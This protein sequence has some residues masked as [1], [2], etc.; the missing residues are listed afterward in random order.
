[1]AKSSMSSKPKTPKILKLVA[2]I[3][4]IAIATVAIYGALTY[5][6]TVLSLSVSFTVGADVERK[7]FD[8]PF[9][10]SW[11]QV[12]VAV[13]SGSALW[14]AR[15][16]NQNETLWSHTSAQGEQTAYKSAWMQLSSGTYNFTFAT[17]GV[18]SL[19]AEITLTSKGGFW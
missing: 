9:L 6:R 5:P 16:L 18:G 14:V 4:I 2:V 15:I 10:N 19:S 8:V 7:Q 12:G 1:M 17:L 11:I 3:A 13:N